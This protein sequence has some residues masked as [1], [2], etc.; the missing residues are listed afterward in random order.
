[1]KSVDAKKLCPNIECVPVALL[2]QS[3]VQAHAPP[4]TAKSENKVSLE[5][6]RD[7]SFDVMKVLQQ[8]VD[9]GSFE[10]ASIDEAYLDL[11]AQ[12]DG[13]VAKGGWEADVDTL[14]ADAS[15][16]T[17]GE[18]GFHALLESGDGRRLL[19][20]ASLTAKIRAAVTAKTTFTMSGGIATNKI[21]AKIASARHKPC[22][23]TTV[24][25]D[26]GKAMILALKITSIPTLGGAFGKKMQDDVARLLQ[27]PGRRQTTTGSAEAVAGTDVA[28][29]EHAGSRGA[30]EGERSAAASTA[31]AL[32]TPAT[33]AP[34]PA[35]TDSVAAAEPPAATMDDL[36]RC[37]PELKGKYRP[38]ELAWL[39]MLCEG[40]ENSRVVFKSLPKSLNSV[41]SF[42]APGVLNE[43][44]MKDWL[45]VLLKDLEERLE[46]DA[47]RYNRRANSLTIHHKGAYGKPARKEKGGLNDRGEG[48]E[49]SRTGRM[50]APPLTAARMLDAALA[51]INKFP[52][53]FPCVRLSIA[54][55]DFV[56]LDQSKPD[57]RSFFSSKKRPANEEEGGEEEEEEGPAPSKSG[58]GK[59]RRASDLAESAG[60]GAGDG[61]GTAAGF[62][63][64]ASDPSSAA[65]GAAQ[66]QALESNLLEDE[67]NWS[68][69]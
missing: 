5:R 54:A 7:A 47:S 28:D 61:R 1:M 15:H 48:G 32:A 33:P 38:E 3:S 34:A 66:H 55:V 40:Q 27:Q 21:T 57:I 65:A 69:D 26:A 8:F 22:M 68:S 10:R 30:A 51:L 53:P 49:L 39:R 23:Q 62:A 9:P 46:K 12:V 16:K 63:W 59:R 35:P 58:G 18:G 4:S 6:Y 13:L 19:I 56:D 2:D 20:A 52:R 14:R 41:K 31:V 25:A 29:A 43:A 42:S 17:L 44:K 11:T 37:L 24:S 36:R 67:P 50:P 45:K 60:A 64:G